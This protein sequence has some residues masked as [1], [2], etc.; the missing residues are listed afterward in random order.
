MTQNL[1]TLTL[2]NVNSFLNHV[3]D[4][5]HFTTI[6]KVDILLISESRFT[7]KNYIQISHCKNY[8]ASHPDGRALGG[9]LIIIKETL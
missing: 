5:I 2:R 6:E 3:Q 8:H 9:T 4:I 7:L 1:L